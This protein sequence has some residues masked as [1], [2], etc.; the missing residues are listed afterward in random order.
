MA[1]HHHPPEIDMEMLW[2]NSSEDSLEDI[3]AIP[4]SR[5][6]IPD[7]T[8]QVLVR[9]A[10]KWPDN[11]AISVLPD[12]QRWRNPVSRTFA[13]LLG[14]VH[15]TANL[16]RDK[17]VERD[18]AVTLIAPNCYSLIVATL[19]AQLA[20]VAAPINSALAADHVAAMVR[21]SGARHLIVASPE[22]DA[23]SWRIAENLGA[24]GLLETVFVIT[25]DKPPV[26][27]GAVPAIPGVTVGVLND[28]A[29]ACDAAEFAGQPPQAHDIAA[30][31][32]TG[33]TTG[34]P[35]LAAHTH[36]NE[37]VDAWMVAARMLLPQD[38]T[39]LAGLPLFHVNAFIVTVLAPLL[40][41]QRAVWLGPLGYRE[42]GLFGVFWKIVEHYGVATMSAV[43]TVYS[44]LSGC[45]VDADISTMRFAVVGA[46]ALPS[47]V[48]REFVSRTGIQLVE[49]YGLTE[50]TCASTSNVPNHSRPGSVGQR[51]PYQRIK[52]VH[53][54]DQDC[55]SN[56]PRGGVGLV[57]IAG[58][59]VFP[60]YLAGRGPQGFVCD[61]QGKLN[62]GW[63]NTGDLGLIDEDGFLHL[64]G[65][66]KDLII[67]GGHNID[68][69]LIEAVM[70]EHPDIT[71]AA[72]VG[73]PD[74]HAGEIPVVYVTVRPGASVSAHELRQWGVEHVVEAAARPK[75]VSIVASIPVTAV[76]KPDKV[77]LRA[78]AARATVEEALARQLAVSSIRGGVENGAPVV[79]VTLS[80]ADARSAVDHILG[81]YPLV[82]RIVI[83]QHGPPCR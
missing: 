50:A 80:D 77:P 79:T 10:T 14:D 66:A 33:G 16:L 37:V 34:T 72:A 82:S 70:L 35:K 36:A 19:A 58:P 20:G 53:V 63:L 24:Q 55:W 68:P 49:G 67:R 51:L 46:S 25:A 15:R 39:V 64:T 22:L 75:H 26:G 11:A 54:D 62:D 17:G 74:P 6:A 73:R 13:E 44:A 83:E 59:T 48:R 61:G 30:V 43:P 42:P 5:R 8:Y 56:V 45:Q 57:A 60:G 81:R 47:T 38:C 52:I 3:E 28:L 18:T 27:D 65:R 7:S 32:H 23:D 76:G 31:F 29:D 1:E 78:D 9:A 2:P 12:T 40:R 4:L 21:L 71:G 41:G 69:A